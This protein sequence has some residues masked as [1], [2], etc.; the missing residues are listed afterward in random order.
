MTSIARPV[1]LYLI[2]YF[3]SFLL[4]CWSPLLPYHLRTS[5]PSDVTQCLIS[6]IIPFIFIVDFFSKESVFVV[7]RFIAIVSVN[8][9]CTVIV[10]MPLCRQFLSLYYW[11][12]LTSHNQRTRILIRPSAVIEHLISLIPFIFIAEITFSKESLL[13]VSVVIAILSAHLMVVVTI[14]IR[15]R[16][17]SK[18][19]FIVSLENV[20]FCMSSWT[21]GYIHPASFLLLCTYTVIAMVLIQTTEERPFKANPTEFKQGKLK[22]IY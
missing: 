19:F 4:L 16:S 3:F 10:W 20:V 13:V 8:L 15:V 7:G 14:L 11:N 12:P 2:C 6:S 22:S 5:I 17:H 18:K 1:F 21:S 9:M